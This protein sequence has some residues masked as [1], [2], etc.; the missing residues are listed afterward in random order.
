MTECTNGSPTCTPGDPCV[1]CHDAD[2][3]EVPAAVRDNSETVTD[4]AFM[5]HRSPMKG[6]RSVAERNRAILHADTFKHARYQWYDVNQGN[7][8]GWDAGHRCRFDMIVNEEGTVTH[9]FH[10]EYFTRAECAEC[11]YSYAIRYVITIGQDGTT[12]S[13]PTPLCDGHLTITRYAARRMNGT[14]LESEPLLIGQHG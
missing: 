11:E 14:V 12:R 10:T 8:I 7:R 4:Y 1:I 13:E 2:T 6:V 3:V 5:G 9:L